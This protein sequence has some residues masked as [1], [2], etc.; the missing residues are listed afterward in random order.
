MGWKGFSHSP[1]VEKPYISEA[2]DAIMENTHTQTSM[3]KPTLIL[4]TL[5]FLLVAPAPDANDFAEMTANFL[6]MDNHSGLMASVEP[7]TPVRE[8]RN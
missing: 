8:D 2:G 1:R 7:K 4:T 3:L 5:L 6:V